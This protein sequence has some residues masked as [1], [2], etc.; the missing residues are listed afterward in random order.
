MTPEHRPPHKKGSDDEYSQSQVNNTYARER[1]GEGGKLDVPD[2]KQSWL[3]GLEPMHRADRRAEPEDVRDER[4][5]EERFVEYRQSASFLWVLW[6]LCCE[7]R[8]G[9]LHTPGQNK[10]SGQGGREIGKDAPVVP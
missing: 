2:I 8:A 3:G 9:P 7:R 6:V 4:G 10:R 5:G 1:G